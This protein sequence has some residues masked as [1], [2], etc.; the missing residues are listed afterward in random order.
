MLRSEPCER[1]VSNV[2]RETRAVE[3]VREQYGQSGVMAET[4][5][6]RRSEQCDVDGCTLIDGVVAGGDLDVAVG[7]GEA[8]DLA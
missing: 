4:R 1:R 6:S 3:T 2:S 8:G 7:L 5:K